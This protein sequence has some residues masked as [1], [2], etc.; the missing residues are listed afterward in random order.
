MGG[1]YL[2]RLTDWRMDRGGRGTLP[3]SDLGGG[4]KVGDPMW[5]RKRYTVSERVGWIGVSNMETNDIQPIIVEL[6]P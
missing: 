6:L 5:T 1:V 4:T 3:S 2:W